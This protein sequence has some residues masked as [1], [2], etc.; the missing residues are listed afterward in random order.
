VNLTGKRTYVTGG[1]G[2]E[3]L[4]EGI[5]RTITTSDSLRRKSLRLHR[6]S[7]SGVSTAEMTGLSVTM[8]ISSSGRSTTAQ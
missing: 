3:W 1:I 2:P 4:H 8:P 5:L 6:P 7:P